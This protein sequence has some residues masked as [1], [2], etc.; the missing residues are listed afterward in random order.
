MEA[1]VAI[2]IFQRSIQKNNL[3]YTRFIGDG[4]TNSFPKV[5]EAQPYGD[6]SIPEKAE[7]VEHVQKRMGTRLRKLKT[8]Y[9]SRTLS[10][11]KPMGG[12]GR[13]TLKMIDYLQVMYGN[14]IRGNKNQLED[15][16]K[17]I[18]A[19]YHHKI[20]TDK[21]PKHGLCSIKWCKYLQLKEKGKQQEYKHKPIPVAIMNAIKPIFYDLTDKTL[22]RKCL[23]GLSQNPNE[24]FNNLIWTIC[25]KNKYHGV[26]TVETAVGLSVIMYNDGMSGL[27][28]VFEN[29]KLDCGTSA[30]S[31]FLNMDKLRFRKA[32]K[33][34]TEASLEARRARRKAR[35]GIADSEDGNA[36]SAGS[37]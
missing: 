29:L 30:Q 28:S 35:L 32:E 4:D 19:I 8:Q 13:L 37:W 21:D 9:G 12:R 7:C 26:Q 23:D 15:M 17:A 11:G 31:V 20:S 25:P 33:R 34:A 3:R 1:D 18:W 16:W 6:P 2:E 24:S 14:A 27:F 36:Y 22:L 10:D 5:S